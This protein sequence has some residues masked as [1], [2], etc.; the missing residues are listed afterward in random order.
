MQTAKRRQILQTMNNNT[1]QK[2]K[3]F[4]AQASRWA[5]PLLA[6]LL[7]FS[8]KTCNER[9]EK[10]VDVSRSLDSLEKKTVVLTNTRGQQVSQNDQMAI[11]GQ[12]ELKRYTDSLFA[13]A[14][15]DNK[16][17]AKVD[18]YTRVKQE[19]EVKDKFA[20]FTD[21]TSP[22]NDYTTGPGE[23]AATEP[24]AAQDSN[25]IKVP[26]AF[27][28]MD[29][30]VMFAG[31]VTREGVNLDSLRV[32]NTIHFRTVTQKTGFLGLGRK[33]VVQVLNSNAQVKTTGVASM[34]VKHN[35]SW[36][37]RWG[38]PIVAAGL[39]AVAMDRLR[40]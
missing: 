40:K 26:Q 5:F 14:R 8:L 30:S 38:K 18:Q 35:P 3:D 32:V 15:A 16:K 37:H 33:T 19:I 13:L 2:L 9:G 6:V 28:Y 31:K 23:N 1:T 20:R 34:A 36:W 21:K 39:T 10:L 4:Y 17:T 25:F 27:Q 7:F 11:D 12:R 22:S 29:S 24:G